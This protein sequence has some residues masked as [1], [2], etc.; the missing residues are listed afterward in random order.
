MRGGR[1]GTRGGQRTAVGRAT[2]GR[3][4]ETVNRGPE[5]L[6][7]QGMDRLA[8]FA[9]WPR[10]GRVKT[11][12]SPALPAELAFALHR[13]MLEDALAEAARARADARALYWADAPADG[14]AF[15]APPGFEVRDQ[16]SGDLGARLERAFGEIAGRKGDRAVVIGSDCPDLDAGVIQSA[17]EALERADLALGPAR[18]GGYYLIGLSRPE[19]P[20]FRGVPWGTA[21]VL[22]HTR[23]AAEA[24]GLRVTLLTPLDD[25]DTP[26]DL[27]RWLARAA[28]RETED[29]PRTRAVLRALGLLP[30]RG[31]EPSFPP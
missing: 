20:V 12:L 4:P 7:S 11:R 1:P 15:P 13:A 30:A 29:A 2:L 10:V 28:L 22:E 25:L 31:H 26:A 27:A 6:W 14:A 17:F 21:G 5:P 3:R 23:A 8:V 16:G 24:A 18:D 9:R 19:A